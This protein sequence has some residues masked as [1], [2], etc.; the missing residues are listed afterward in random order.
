MSLQTLLKD[1][2]AQKLNNNCDL[3][4]D[5]PP[6]RHLTEFYTDIKGSQPCRTLDLHICVILPTAHPPCIFR[7]TFTQLTARE[8]TAAVFKLNKIKCRKGNHCNQRAAKWKPC[9]QAEWIPGDVGDTLT[10]KV[11]K[12]QSPPPLS[13]P[14]SHNVIRL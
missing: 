12:C 1:I 5:S 4:T 7:G 8:V 13:L 11:V 9:G 14:P 2:H 6:Y 3:A 10:I